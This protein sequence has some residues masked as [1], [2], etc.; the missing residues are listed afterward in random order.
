MILYHYTTL[1]TFFGQDQ[2]DHVKAVGEVRLEA[3]MTE[4]RPSAAQTPEWQPVVWLTGEARVD[5]PP[6]KSP[7][8]N[9]GEGCYIRI[10]VAVPSG[11]R[12]LIS[13]RKAFPQLCRAIW[14]AH[15]AGE[16]LACSV[17][18]L[19]SGFIDRR[20]RQ[21]WV[22]AGTIPQTMWRGAE[23]VHGPWPWWEVSPV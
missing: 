10:A 21:W 22:Y 15:H 13:I 17:R 14:Q 8:A 3:V 11:D 19:A 2:L 12:R 1:A 18:D 6:G 16:P 5:G 4:L 9:E 20:S 23:I 7:R